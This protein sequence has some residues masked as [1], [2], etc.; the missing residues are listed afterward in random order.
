MSGNAEEELLFRMGIM[1]NLEHRH[2]D[3]TE[4]ERL[5]LHLVE[6]MKL[7]KH[8]K[9]HQESKEINNRYDPVLRAWQL[10]KIAG[11]KEDSLVTFFHNHKNYF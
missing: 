9:E 7:K 11:G 2:P 3:K 8:P 10:Y 4:L 6:V 1:L 5:T